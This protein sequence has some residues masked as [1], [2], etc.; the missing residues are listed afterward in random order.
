MGVIEVKSDEGYDITIC[1]LDCLSYELA[2][3]FMKEFH[4]DPDGTHM[5]MIKRLPNG[6]NEYSILKNVKI[7]G[8]ESALLGPSIAEN[9]KKNAKSFLI[10]FTSNNDYSSHVV[11]EYSESRVMAYKELLENQP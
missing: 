4:L 6:E 11:S 5:V 3:R 7:T 10:N 9:A 1:G 2:S 8:S